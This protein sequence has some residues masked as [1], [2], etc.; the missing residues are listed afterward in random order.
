M[1]GYSELDRRLDKQMAQQKRRD[2]KHYHGGNRA[3]CEPI[4]I[5]LQPII[6]T[7]ETR[8]HCFF[9]GNPF[10]EV[11]NKILYISAYPAHTYE[12]VSSDRITCKRCKQ[13]YI[14]V[15]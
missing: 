4:A 15:V 14:K 6:Q 2:D 7:E 5:Y 3:A 13:P 10:I 12:K 9:C 8:L 11:R 1:S